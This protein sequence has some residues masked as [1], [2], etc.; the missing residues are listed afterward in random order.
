VVVDRAAVEK[1]KPGEIVLSPLE[2]KLPAALKM[3]CQV[4]P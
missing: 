2:N 4:C 3:L 1:K